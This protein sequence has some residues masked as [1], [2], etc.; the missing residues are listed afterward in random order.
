MGI[1]RVVCKG[2]LRMGVTRVAINT[3][4][5]GGPNVLVSRLTMDEVVWE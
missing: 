4:Q 1:I 2:N 5:W 3:W